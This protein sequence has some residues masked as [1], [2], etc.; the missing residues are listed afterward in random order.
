LTRAGDDKILPIVGS[1][2]AFYGGIL[3]LYAVLVGLITLRPLP[4]SSSAPSWVPLVQIWRVLTSPEG[5]TYV[6]VGA[7]AGN[8]ALFVPLGWLLPMI[9]TQL[10]PGRVV[11][12][13]AACSIGIELSQLLM[14]EGRSPT[15]D[16]VLLNTLGTLIGVIMFFAPRAAR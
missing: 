9:W 10:S 2:R 3:A 8:I 14:I 1:H 12:I 15:T 6:D 16:D 5:S 7:L 13:G 11:A 4:S